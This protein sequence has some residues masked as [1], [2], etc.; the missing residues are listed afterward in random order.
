M[1]IKATLNV[2]WAKIQK[3]TKNTKKF[4]RCYRTLPK[5]LLLT[6]EVSRKIVSNI[7]H[8]I[9]A[10]ATTTTYDKDDSKYRRRLGFSSPAVTEP[11][12][13]CFCLEQQRWQQSGDAFK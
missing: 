4:K 13:C 2:C 9:R 10:R 12:D 5:C 1:Y 6:K 11:N 3:S 7:E 8:R